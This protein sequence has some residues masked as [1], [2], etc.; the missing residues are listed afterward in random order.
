MS[1]SV[2]SK[3]FVLASAFSLQSAFALS[4]FYCPVNYGTIR[5]GMSMG[6]VQQFCGPPTSQSTKK[7]FTQ[8]QA[9]VTQYYFRVGGFVVNSQNIGQPQSQQATTRT[10]SSSVLV[11]SMIDGKVSGIS[12]DGGSMPSA[13]VCGS[14]IAE[15]N[16][17]NQ[18]MNA[19]GRPYL[20]NKTKANVGELKQ[21]KQTTWFYQF[22]PYNSVTL[23]FSDD[24]LQSITK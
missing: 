1:R 13:T 23:T 18:V 14:P 8:A 20:V 24:T 6:Q 15:G 4:S 7:T 11:V 2:F 3:I 21:V 19:C 12:V 22:T 10:G 9:P 5:I 17:K 16:S